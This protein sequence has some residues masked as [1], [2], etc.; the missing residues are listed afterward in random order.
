MNFAVLGDA[1]DVGPLLRAIGAASEHRLTAYAQADRLEGEIRAADPDATRCESVDALRRDD[2]FEA[3]IVAGAAKPLL[4]AAREMAEAGKSLLLAPLSEQDLGVVYE[5]SL[6]TA[7]KPITLFPIFPLRTH[8]LVTQ[9]REMLDEGELGAVQYL[10]LERTLRPV[11]GAGPLTKRATDAAFLADVDLL[12]D[13]GGNYNQVTTLLTGTNEAVAAI[14]TTLGSNQAPQATWRAKAGSEDSWQ[15]TIAGM[16]STALLTGEPAQSSLTLSAEGADFSFPSTSQRADWGPE[17]LAAF[18]A[19]VA[20][21]RAAPNWE[22]MQRGMELMSATD[23]SLKR[24]R[25]IELFFEA[26][27]ERSTFKTQMTAIGCSL[28]M[29]TLLGVIAALVGGQA[30]LPPTVMSILRI[31]VFAPL[32]IFLLLQLL[33]VFTKPASPSPRK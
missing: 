25:T 2:S 1:A 11:G 26:H 27:S 29:L 30:G 24:K 16:R 17:T 7:D 32:G 20:G 3:L 22:D 19:A 21:D 10:E 31:L 28:I 6:V 18:Q 33:L 13:L 15:L 14:T 23:R 8:P 9:L 5:L 12:R 4:D